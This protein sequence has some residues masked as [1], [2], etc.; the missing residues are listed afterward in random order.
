MCHPG[1][2]WD[3]NSQYARKLSRLRPRTFN[4]VIRRSP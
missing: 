3:D 4:H 2:H 1:F